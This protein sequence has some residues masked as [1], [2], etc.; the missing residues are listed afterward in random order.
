MSDGMS[1]A[2]IA[3][4]LGMTKPDIRGE[5]SAKPLFALTELFVEAASRIESLEAEN[6]KLRKT[7]EAVEQATRLTYE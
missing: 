2:E 6:A 7:I 1:M 3:D 5:M 4:A